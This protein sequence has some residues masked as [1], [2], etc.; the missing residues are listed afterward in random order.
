MA[1]KRMIDP[2]FWI[3]EKLGTVEP[4]VRLLFMGL[5]SQADDEGRLNGHPSLVKSLIFPY[6]H[7]IQLDNVEEWL[8]LLAAPERK[9]IQRYEVNNQKYIL[10]TNFKKHQTINK[11]QKSKL[12]APL[13]DYGST[14]VVIHEDDGSITAQEKRKEEKRREEEEKEKGIDG[15]SVP[16]FDNPHMNRIQAAI[17]K[18][19]VECKG[20][21]QL[22]KL[23]AYIGVVDI[24]VI[25]FALQESEN[26]HVPYALSIL[27]RLKREGKTTKES[28]LPKAGEIDAKTRTSTRHEQSD[29]E[30]KPITGGVTGAL[31]SRW[32]EKA[33]NVIQMPQ[34][35][36]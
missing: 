2:S 17:K 4:I 15:V 31:P 19:N 35:S 34:V 14:T 36:G 26:I 3:D 32:A 29:P 12:P 11:P 23:G 13:D 9:V 7:E 22:E 16:T 25:E 21:G 8:S 28:I 20:I 24:E 18:Y 27:E 6:D 1:R 5:I 10:I 33:G 30:D